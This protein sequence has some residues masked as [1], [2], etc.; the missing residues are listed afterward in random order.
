MRPEYIKENDDP[1][2]DWAIGEEVV[3]Q[4]LNQ[5]IDEE[6]HVNLDVD[7]VDLGVLDSSFDSGEEP[8]DKSDPD[9]DSCRDR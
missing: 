9:Y 5:E 7:E 4:L 3:G 8:K 2:E 6:Q 1:G